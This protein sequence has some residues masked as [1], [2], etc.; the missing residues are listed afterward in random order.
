[1]F[2]N[3]RSG[4][5]ARNFTTNV[6]KILVL[7][8]SSE[9][10]FSRKLPLGAPAVFGIPKP[11]ILYTTSKYYL[12]SLTWVIFMREKLFWVCTLYKKCST[13]GFVD[14]D[15]CNRAKLHHR[16]FKKPYRYDTDKN[17][18]LW[19]LYAW[20]I[21]RIACFTSLMFTSYCNNICF[22]KLL[23]EKLRSGKIY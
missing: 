7:K 9:R 14:T 8:S 2:E 22:R 23:R 10:I 12:D 19:L 17:C 6:K 18:A 5:Q 4:R 1:M 20:L 21:S 3:P 11:W 16:P 13:F 15:Y